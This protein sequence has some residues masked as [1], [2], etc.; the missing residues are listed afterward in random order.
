M[1]ER[2]LQFARRRWLLLIIT[3]IIFMGLRL[4]SSFSILT[5]KVTNHKNGSTASFNLSS[6]DSGKNVLSFTSNEQEV[7]KIIRKSALEITASEAGSSAFAV[8]S[9][10]G[11]FQKSEVKM[12]LVATP[13]KEY[14][15]NEPGVCTSYSG[16][17]LYSYSCSGATS[18]TIHQPATTSQPSYNITKGLGIGTVEGVVSTKSG[19]V[20]IAQLGDEDDMGAQKHILYL[21]DGQLNIVKQKTADD[22]DNSKKYEIKPFRDGFLVYGIDFSEAKYFSAID[23]QAENITIP[24]SEVH[25]NKLET[26]GSF[27]LLTIPSTQDV[28]DPESSN[29][30]SGVT[31]GSVV[32]ISQ[33]QPKQYNLSAKY[34]S[35]RFCSKNTLCGVR[36]N[37]DKYSDK[38]SGILDVY[39]IGDKLV[40]LYSINDVVGFHSSGG[41]LGVIRSNDILSLEPFSGIG[42]IVYSSNG[43]RICDLQTSGDNFLV[44][45]SGPDGRSF[46]LRLDSSKV[47]DQIDQKIASLYELGEVNTVSVYKN[48]IFISPNFGDLTYID[49]LG[50]YDYE[51]AVKASNTAVINQEIDKL[52]LRKNYLIKIN[53]I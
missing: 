38:E 18:V 46:M 53:G 29:S 20:V 19:L 32:V 50:G 11:F 49:S 39:S 44:C 27:I 4:I 41:K 14:I 33:G 13:G 9:T 12:N 47:D 15:G 45:V 25:P 10:K 24:P 7:T 34:A 52:G 31:I 30:A 6:Q 36:K 37:Q 23:A 3:F 21:L 22:L 43:S 16:N 28:K 40:R 5:I 2:V 35:I 42:S 51:P 8:T 1:L 26:Y 17:I 48:I